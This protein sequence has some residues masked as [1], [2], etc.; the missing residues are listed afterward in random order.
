MKKL[1]YLLFVCSVVFVGCNRE[2]TNGEPYLPTINT[3][4]IS[5]ITSVSAETGGE[6]ISDG[7]VNIQMQVNSKGVCWSANL[8][9]TIQNDTTLNGFG[10]T[11]FT[12][13]INGLTPNTTYYVRAYA[14]NVNGVGYGENVSFTTQP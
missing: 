4:A 11:D 7:G 10:L 14:T 6:T 3:V 1:F 2:L 5:N 8:N 12:T 9:P 13:T